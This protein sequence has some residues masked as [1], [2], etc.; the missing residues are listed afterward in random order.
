M[1]ALTS[2]EQELEYCLREL[3]RMIEDRELVRNTLADGAVDWYARMLRMVSVL[4][5]TQN[6]LGLGEKL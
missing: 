2:K 5:R 1:E 4:K 6:V 3:W